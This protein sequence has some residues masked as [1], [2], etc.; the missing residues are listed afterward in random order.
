M[1]Q[2]N[3]VAIMDMSLNQIGGD[4]GL[5]CGDAYETTITTS[6]KDIGTEIASWFTPKQDNVIELIKEHMLACSHL[7]TEQQAEWYAYYV[8]YYTWYYSTQSVY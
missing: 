7:T 8:S 1:N 5:A 6:L 3:N 4:I 2:S